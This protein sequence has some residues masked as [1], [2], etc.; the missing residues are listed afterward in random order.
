MDAGRGL[1]LGAVGR[2]GRHRLRQHGSHLRRPRRD[3]HRAIRQRGRAAQQPRGNSQ[4]RR[5][6]TRRIG[7]PTGC[8]P[9]CTTAI[10]STTRRRPSTAP[11]PCPWLPSSRRLPAATGPSDSAFSP[12]AGFAAG[13]DFNNAAEGNQ[14]Y[15]SFG[16]LIKVLPGVSYRL[17]D[18]LS[19]GGTIGLAASYV[20]LDTPFNIQTGPLA[21]APVHMDLKG[22]GYAPTWSLG[23]QYEMSPVD[24]VWSGLHE[25][26]SVQSRRAHAGPGL[27]FRAKPHSN[28]VQFA[29]QRLF[30]RN[31]SAP[32][33]S[34]SS[35]SISG[36][37]PT[38][39]GMT[40]HMPFR[41]P[42]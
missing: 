26:G 9:T 6:G 33:S 17:A 1:T 12:L 10:P 11:W 37:R 18:G 13:W 30:G 21:G 38:S 8:S 23:M 15:K 22:D 14:S 36:S 31:R 24:N 39:S 3:Q 20:A 28:G 4:R 40:G 16:S 35:R 29:A 41:T 7:A 25:R 2:R 34:T 27:R 32:A 5:G 42:A 19:V